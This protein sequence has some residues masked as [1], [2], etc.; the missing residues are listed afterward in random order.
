[1]DGR[2]LESPGAGRV[3]GLYAV[4]WIKRGPTGLIGTNKSD[5]KQTVALMLEDARELAS[6][7]REPVSG[8]D[9]LLAERGV[10]VVRLDDW[11]RLDELETANGK[12]LGK[13]RE[14]FYEVAPMLE[15]LR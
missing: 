5:A 7:E 2:V 9:Q 13:V 4:G 1:V 6:A 15:A 14:K 8:I 10:R 12:R 3:P 11:R